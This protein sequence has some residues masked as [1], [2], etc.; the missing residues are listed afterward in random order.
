MEGTG[1]KKCHGFWVSFTKLKRK[2]DVEA[3]AG[4]PSVCDVATTTELFAQFSWNSV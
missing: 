2:P 4:R 3:M 1:R